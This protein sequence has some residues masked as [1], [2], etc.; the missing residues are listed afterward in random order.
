MAVRAIVFDIGGVLYDWHPRFLFERMTDDVALVDRIVGEAVTHAWHFQHDAGR[1][2][3]DTSAELIAQF[4]EFEMYIRAFGARFNETIRGPIPGTL[5]ILRELDAAGVPLF[6]ITNFSHEFFPPFAAVHAE[7]FD[8]FR[9]IIVSGAEKLTKPDP[10]IYASALSRFGLE[11]GEAMFIDDVL[12]N[13]ESANANGFVGHHFQGSDA[14]RKV[15]TSL[16]LIP[17]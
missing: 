6:C 11:P 14:L 15:L 16:Q 9:D 5:D 4:P 17:G 8:R 13:A 10:A 7:I 2:F 3:A 1:D 12:A